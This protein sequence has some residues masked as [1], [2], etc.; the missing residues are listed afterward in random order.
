MKLVRW[1]SEAPKPWLLR[2]RKLAGHTEER[3]LQLLPRLEQRGQ[4][5]QLAEGLR[6]AL[7]SKLEG[8]RLLVPEYT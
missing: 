1:D 7:E 3:L 2:L 4:Q 5:G 6:D 8:E